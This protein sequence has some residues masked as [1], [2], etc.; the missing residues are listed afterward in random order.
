VGHGDS[1]E[2]GS[3]RLCPSGERAGWSAAPRSLGPLPRPSAPYWGRAAC[4]GVGPGRHGERRSRAGGRRRAAGP[5]L[6]SGVHV[7]KY[8][9]PLATVGLVAASDG[10]LPAE[11]RTVHVG[12]PA[13]GREGGRRWLDPSLLVAAC[14]LCRAERRPGC[15]CPTPSPSESPIAWHRSRRADPLATATSSV[16]CRAR[17][18]TENTACACSPTQV[19][20]VFSERAPCTRPWPAP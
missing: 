17:T 10:D 20:V 14:P 19:K 13:A 16:C 6:L 18:F 1:E 12:T 5:G 8:S 9:R 15:R 4:P 11:T 7:Q 2:G 3:E